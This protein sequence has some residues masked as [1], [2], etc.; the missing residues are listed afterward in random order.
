MAQ[1]G[2]DAEAEQAGE[3]EAGGG[4]GDGTGNLRVAEG[5]AVRR[6]MPAGQ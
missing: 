1:E 3:D 4:A 2:A 5:G 6:E